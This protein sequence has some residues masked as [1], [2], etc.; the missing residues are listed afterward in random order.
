MLPAYDRHNATT[1]GRA[2]LHQQACTVTI[3]IP[4]SYNPAN[5]NTT[6]WDSLD[7]HRWLPCSTNAAQK[8]EFR[9]VRIWWWCVI[10]PTLQE[11]VQPFGDWGCREDNSSSSKRKFYQHR[12]ASIP[13]EP[14]RGPIPRIC[15]TGAWHVPYCKSIKTRQRHGKD[16]AS[17]THRSEAW[18]ASGHS[19]ATTRNDALLY[20]VSVRNRRSSPSKLASPRLQP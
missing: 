12:R 7:V 4:T 3:D 11:Q 1:L 10:L 16:A 6:R 2:Q 19:L 13:A 17:C 8:M 14:R 20:S 9:W 18:L 5:K 15:Y